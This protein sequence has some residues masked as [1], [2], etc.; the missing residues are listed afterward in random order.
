MPSAEQ[1]VPQPG[2]AQEPIATIRAIAQRRAGRIVSV[3]RLVVV[4]GILVNLVFFPPREQVAASITNRRALHRVEPGAPGRSLARRPAVLGRVDGAAGRPARADHAAGR[5]R[6]PLR[7]HLGH[8]V[9][10]RRVRADPDPGRVPAATQGHCGLRRGLDPGL[11]GRRHRRPCPRLTRPA[12]CRAARGV[13]RPGQRGRRP[14]VLG[15]AVAHRD[16]RR[17]GAAPGEP[18]RADHVRRRPGPPRPGRGAARRRVAERAGGPPGRRRSP[19]PGPQRGTATGRAGAARGHRAAAVLPVRAAPGRAGA[20]GPGTG[21]G[22][23]GPADRC[24]RP[25]PGRGGLPG[26]DAGYETDRLLYHCARELLGNAAKHARADLVRVRLYTTTDE[27]R[28]EVADDGVGL[29]ADGLQQRV[30][31]GHIGLASQRVRIES[32]GGTLVLSANRPTGTL[33]VVTLPRRARRATA[34]ATASAPA[35]APADTDAGP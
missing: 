17:P 29:P 14:A 18:A 19:G 24:T 20:P 22:A 27:I 2:G 31:Q 16:D 30:G 21:T 25:L 32:S 28:L 23:A 1:A 4:V 8:S 26:P 7:P 9:H 13:H 12:L 15:A 35:S 33:A 34:S 3:L 5:L 6:Q 11:R 10:R